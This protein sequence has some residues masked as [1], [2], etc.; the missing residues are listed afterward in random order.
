M[1]LNNLEKSTLVIKTF[2][3][4]NGI[5]DFL[6]SDQNIYIGGS[7]PFMCLS[8]KISDSSKIEVGDIDIYT[9]N[10]PLLFRNLNKSFIMREIVK[11]GVNV[12]FNIDSSEIPIQV[13]TSPFDD[14]KDEVLDEY[15][16]GMVSVGFHPYTSKFIIHERFIE[17]IK[18]NQFEV[19]HERTNPT[20]VKKLETRAMELFECSIVEIKL[21]SNTDYRPY[22]KNK[23][24]IN[25][26]NDTMPSPPYTQLYGN[27]YHCMG[28]TEKQD[29]LICK[30]CQYRISNHFNLTIKSNDFIKKYKKVVVFGGL[31]GLGK[32]IADEIIEIGEN[33]IQVSRT[34]RAGGKEINTYPF[35]LEKYA[36]KYETVNKIK[37]SSNKKINLQNKT[38]II[39]PELLNKL[40][41]AELV[42]FNAYQTLEGD[43][44][45]WNT[46]L[47]T[48]DPELS[49]KRFKINC[50][51]YTGLMQEILE[52]RK[53]YISSN[54]N[55]QDQIFVWIDANESR[56]EGKLSDGKHLELNMAKTACKQIF[57]TNANVMAGLGIIF[58]CWDCGWCSFHGISVDKI[59]SKSM[60]LV[61]PK[62]SSQALISYISTLNI[63]KLYQ[64]KKYIHD[65]TFYKCVDNSNID[66]KLKLTSKELE[67]IIEIEVKKKLKLNKKKL[68]KDELYEEVS[69]EKKNI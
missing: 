45:I 11:T 32:I 21:D 52:A 50:W 69:D 47:D 40:L 20:R 34:G 29:Y 66:F 13:I 62:L 6:S 64:E 48:F 4:N 39:N 19:I 56:F 38:K 53:N 49:E 30:I 54:V 18:K 36:N 17:Q 46:N 16:C 65:M 42:I 68:D 27:K 51:G 1:E 5:W 41:E 2:L 63:D 14:F 58:L 24:I 15:D 55:Y 57:Y 9:T 25:S 43:H 44:S 28:C 8:S 7:L 23:Q 37:S 61:P 3:K 22:W 60:Y 59:A 26:I 10:C 35:D 31:N 67:N 12:K 33:S